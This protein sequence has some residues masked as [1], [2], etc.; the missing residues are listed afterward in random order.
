MRSDN[1]AISHA[2]NLVEHIALFCKFLRKRGFRIGPGQT[3]D[4]LRAIEIVGVEAES[5][6]REAL[7]LVLCS[8]PWEQ[9]H[10]DA[11][12][13]AFFRSTNLSA[14]DRAMVQ[15]RLSNQTSESGPKDEKK[16]SQHNP[17]S[18]DDPVEPSLANS[19]PNTRGRSFLTSLLQKNAPTRA[20]IPVENLNE[21]IAA[22][23]ILVNR[24][25]RQKGRKKAAGQRGGHLDF[26]RT[27]RINMPVGG[28]I[29]KLAWKSPKPQKVR[30]VLFCDGSR[31]MT[32][33]AE[34][35]LQFAYA[36]TC[37]SRYVE[38]FLFSTRVKRVTEKL[39]QTKRQGLSALSVLGAEWGGGTR[40]GESLET[41]IQ[42]YGGRMLGRKTVVIIASDGLETGSVETMQQAMKTIYARSA[43]VVWLNPLLAIPGYEPTARGM[44]TALTYIDLFS[45]ANDPVSFK[46][47][48]A[49]FTCRR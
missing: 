20:Q 10:F 46:K 47:M 41:F 8:S 34:R 9:E 26:R 33:F 45:G 17:I 19:E 2:G 21:T 30:F 6:V 11:I 1:P 39:Y 29:F 31:S 36:L 24:V 22:A 35:F 48:A 15:M 12:Y 5:Q 28:E 49:A 4:A 7:R 14:L 3:I 42:Q 25:K 32:G 43:S 18:C 38:V 37:C 16:E 23:R 27:M 40:I 13:K 44:H